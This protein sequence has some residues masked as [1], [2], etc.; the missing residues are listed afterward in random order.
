MDRNKGSK[1][2][3]ES[4][5]R[6]SSPPPQFQQLD[7]PAHHDMS[8][9]SPARKLRIDFFWAPTVNATMFKVDTHRIWICEFPDEQ[10][11]SYPGAA[12]SQG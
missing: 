4:E 10:V 7:A 8:W 2:A 11:L 12:R 1:V 9:T 5:L 3:E 6:S